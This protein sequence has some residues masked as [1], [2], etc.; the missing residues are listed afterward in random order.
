MTLN[1]QLLFDFNQNWN[2]VSIWVL[3]WNFDNI[4]NRGGRKWLREES[5]SL[6]VKH[7]AILFGKGKR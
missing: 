3:H 4:V 6:V 1:Y 5:C 7:E 2:K